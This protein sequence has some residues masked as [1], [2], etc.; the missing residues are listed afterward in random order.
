MVAGSRTRSSYIH[1]SVV[2]LARTGELDLL[3]VVAPSD[4]ANACSTVSS[5]GA[6]SI[7]IV[8]PRWIESDAGGE[9]G[10][11]EDLFGLALPARRGLGGSGYQT[12]A[13]CRPAAHDMHHDV[14]RVVRSTP[15]GS[16][17]VGAHWPG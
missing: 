1:E 15:T 14:R 12:S 3:V 7:S 4:H 13:A 9:P 17:R 10:R 16:G 5:L 2:W 6:L 11:V 8:V